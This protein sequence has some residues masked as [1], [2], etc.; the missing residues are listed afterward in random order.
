MEYVIKGNTA[1]IR[2]DKGDEIF[3]SIK[4]FAKSEK[5][6]A[7][8]VSGIGAT[9]N[10]EIGVYDLEKGCYVRRRFSGNREILALVGNISVMDGEY[11]HLHITTQGQEDYAVGGHL[12]NAVVSMTAEIFVNVLDYELNRAYDPEVKINTLRF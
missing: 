12:F 1:I 3:S 10:M 11:V 5:I 7:A 4:E 6:T 8:S 9:D 2:L